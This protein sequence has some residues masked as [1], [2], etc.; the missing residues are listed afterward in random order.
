MRLGLFGMPLHPA[1]RPRSEVYDEDLDRIVY[2]DEL[3]FDEVFVGEHISCPTEPIAAPLMFLSALLSRTTNIRLGTGVL[4]LP[5]HHPAIV[6]AEVAQFDHLA[7]GRFLF[8]IG[9][10]GLA[11]DMELFGVLD[12][13]T[14]NEKLSESIDIILDLWQTEP[15]FRVQTKHYDFGIEETVIDELHVGHL[16]RPYQLPHPPICSTAM[17]PFS[18]SITKAVER[19]WSPM[20]A[21]FCPVNVVA[22]HWTKYVEGCENIGVEPTGDDWRV[23]RN[24]VIAETDEEARDRALDPT[25]G[26]AFYFSYLW[27]VLKKADYSA[28]M[29]SDPSVADEDITVDDLV[30]SMV[31]YGSPD[32]VTQKLEALREETGPFGTLLMAM[33]DGGPTGDANERETMRLLAQEVAPKIGAR[34]PA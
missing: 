21:N 10:G 32:T 33:M 11:S 29:K 31:I 8:G 25:G 20:T 14:R 18:S 27:E 9:P 6:A 5:N 28:V 15:P 4:A 16:P 12:A 19:G 13:Q 30:E 26:N 1:D 3:G 17:S 7:K 23:S 24:I 2:A 22:S 34:I